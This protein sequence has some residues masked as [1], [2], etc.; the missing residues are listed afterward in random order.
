MASPYED[1][2]INTASLNAYQTI[3]GATIVAPSIV[4]YAYEEQSIVNGLH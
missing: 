3:D 1:K 2:L 4:W